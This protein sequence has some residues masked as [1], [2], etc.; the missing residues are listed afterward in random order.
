[1]GGLTRGLCG[2]FPRQSQSRRLGIDSRNAARGRRA[3]IANSI[4]QTATINRRDAHLK[5]NYDG[6]AQFK[7]IEGTDL[8]YA[9]NTATPVIR[10]DDKSF[11]AVQNAVWFIGPAPEGP[12]AVATSVPA[13]IGSAIPP[14]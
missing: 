11:Y 4:P 13:A 6:E 2:R 14:S 3:L 8:Q 9:V 1:M 5:V 7:T 12:W 10:V